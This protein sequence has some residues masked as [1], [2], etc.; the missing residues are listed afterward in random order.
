ESIKVVIAPSDDDLYH[1]LA[2]SAIH[3]FS[4][5]SAYPMITKAFRLAVKSGLKNGVL[6]EPFKWIGIKGKIRRIKYTIL[7]IRYSKNIDFIAATGELGVLQYEKIGFDSHK[8]FEWGYFVEN[9]NK[10][11]Y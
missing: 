2:I 1:L 5:I 7:R 4:G 9:R 11:V 3:V 6:L 10:S 8:V